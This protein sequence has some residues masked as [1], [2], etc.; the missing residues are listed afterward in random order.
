MRGQPGLHRKHG[1]PYPVR[2]EDHRE[3][4][5]ARRAPLS[6]R[7]RTAV[8]A[9]IAIAVWAVFTV[10]LP[11]TAFP[12]DARLFGLPLNAA[13][14]LPVG[15]PALALAMFWFTARQNRDDERFRDHD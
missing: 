2:V 14:S 6:F 3:T 12:P 7:T 5:M 11:L 13:L 9:A 1:L 4:V 10:V 15:L 8:S